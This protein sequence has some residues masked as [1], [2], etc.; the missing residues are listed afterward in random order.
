MAVCRVPCETTDRDRAAGTVLPTSAMAGIARDDCAV[1]GVCL[2]LRGRG[3]ECPPWWRASRRAREG[4]WSVPHGAGNGGG[5][6]RQRSRLHPTPGERPGGC[7][8]E[9]RGGAGSTR[10]RISSD[11]GSRRG[12]H[13]SGH[14][15]PGGR[16]GGRRDGDMGQ[17]HSV[18]G[19]HR[20]GASRA[21]I[22]QSI[23]YLANAPTATLP[24]A[25]AGLDLVCFVIGSSVSSQY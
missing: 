2:R 10:T 6:I 7:Q 18:T 21:G 22:L 13:G 14:T 5:L 4:S 8:L 9:E 20:E 19:G 11:R 23:L 24:P 1:G 16:K 3:A 12:D 17:A 15:R 25:P